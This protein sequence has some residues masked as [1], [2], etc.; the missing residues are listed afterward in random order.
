MV[1]LLRG[2]VT[3]YAI[4]CLSAMQHRLRDGDQ[5]REAAARATGK[6]GPI[7]VAAGLK[8]AAGTAALLATELELSQALG[9]G[10]TLTILVGLVVAVTPI[11]ALLPS[12]GRPP[13]AAPRCR[14]GRYGG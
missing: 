12:P 13:P 14:S 9:P 11:P 10:M 7:V 5:P 3:D 4:F 8:V 6:I 1:A 2:I